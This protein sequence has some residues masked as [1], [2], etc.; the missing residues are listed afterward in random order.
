M[1]VRPRC[2][3]FSGLCGLS[4]SFPSSSP[5][6]VELPV[7]CGSGEL[8]PSFSFS[9]VSCSTFASHC[10]NRRRNIQHEYNVKNGIIPKTVIK[11]VRDIIDIGAKDD[12][13]KS[14]ARKEKGDISY[15]KL[16][17]KDKDA[18]IERM[19]KEMKDAARRLEFEQAAFLRDKIKEIRE[20]K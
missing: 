1:A 4:S 16:S 19:T 11:G 3:A 2:L 15:R 17:K 20:S 10:P 13:G 7:W 6:P 12:G 14:E 18:L 9:R 5:S 8:P